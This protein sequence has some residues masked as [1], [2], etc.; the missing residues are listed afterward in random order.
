MGSAGWARLIHTANLAKVNEQK[1][2]NKVGGADLA[3]RHFGF[4]LALADNNPCLDSDR[5]DFDVDAFPIPTLC[6]PKHGSFLD[7][8][9]DSLKYCGD[10]YSDGDVRPYDNLPQDNYWGVVCATGKINN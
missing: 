1:Y 3:C 6:R 2:K 5:Q 9:R 4:P 8:I 7:C 10:Y